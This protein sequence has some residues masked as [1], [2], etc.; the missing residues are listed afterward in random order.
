[1]I[2][3]DGGSASSFFPTSDVSS[4]WIKSPLYNISGLPLPP[5]LPFPREM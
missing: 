3:P 2:P 1:M 5:H 4:G